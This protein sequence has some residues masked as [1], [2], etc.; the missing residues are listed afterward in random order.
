MVNIWFWFQSPVYT[1]ISLLDTDSL[2]AKHLSQKQEFCV[3][4]NLQTDKDFGEHQ[5][6]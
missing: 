6:L 3:W 1:I 5:N 2:E 4:Q